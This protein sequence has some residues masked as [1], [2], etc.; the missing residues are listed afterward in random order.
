MFLYVVKSSFFLNGTMIE[1]CGYHYFFF[2]ICTYNKVMQCYLE[3]NT[4]DL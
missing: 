3:V 1:N 2:D 4:E